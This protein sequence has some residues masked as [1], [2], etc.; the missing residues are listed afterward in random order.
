VACGSSTDKTSKMEDAD[1]LEAVQT[2]CDGG[3]LE[4]LIDISPHAAQLQA[5]RMLQRLI[6]DEAPTGGRG[7]NSAPTK[8]ARKPK[9]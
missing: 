9:D 1:I 7:A 6:S 5:R 3:S 8:R 2:N 4:G